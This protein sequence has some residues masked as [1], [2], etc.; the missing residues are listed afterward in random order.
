[1]QALVLPFLLLPGAPCSHYSVRRAHT[2]LQ[3]EGRLLSYL[4]QIA[5]SSCDWNPAEGF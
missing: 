5:S 3:Y 4:F 1:M 2:L